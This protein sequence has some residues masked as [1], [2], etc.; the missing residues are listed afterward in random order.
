MTFTHRYNTKIVLHSSVKFIWNV[1]LYI[2]YLYLSQVLDIMSILLSY[3]FWHF[4]PECELWNCARW[5][6][7]SNYSGRNLVLENI[8]R[9]T[10]DRTRQSSPSK[11]GRRTWAQVLEPRLSGLQSCFQFAS[12]SSDAWLSSNI[13]RDEYSVI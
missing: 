4:F 3:F 9:D 12:H 11:A 10:E 5:Q 13:R 8:N 7:S 6:E 1:Y 2:N